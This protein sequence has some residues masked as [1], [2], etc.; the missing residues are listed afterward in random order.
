MDRWTERI[1][2]IPSTNQSINQSMVS[3]INLLVIFIWFIPPA[4]SSLTKKSTDF[5]GQS[6]IAEFLLRRLSFP[7]KF[8]TPFN[9]LNFR[10]VD[11]ACL[12]TLLA[13]PW[14]TWW[15]NAA[16]PFKIWRKRDQSVKKWHNETL[17]TQ[18]LSSEKIPRPKINSRV[19]LTVVVSVRRRS[20][21][22]MCHHF[23]QKISA[24]SW[25]DRCTDHFLHK[26][27]LQW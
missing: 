21:R 3:T 20:I 11:Q 26:A 12:H 25:P 24:E 9:D 27:A 8:H 1:N 23:P 17:L 10:I 5:F 6:N 22:T 14:R 2:Q 4:V 7:A 13:L 19:L 18:P 16:H 15:T